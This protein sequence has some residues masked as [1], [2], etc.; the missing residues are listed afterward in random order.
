MPD[1][2][3]SQKRMR[4]ERVARKRNAGIK[5][6]V[7]T[8]VKKVR[9]A[10]QPDTLTASLN[11]ACSALDKAAKR[12]VIHWKNAGRQKSRLAKHVNAKKA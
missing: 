11:A 10:T 6:T 4:Q 3:S 8:A 2:K 7:R 1:L 12:G 5:S 9:Q